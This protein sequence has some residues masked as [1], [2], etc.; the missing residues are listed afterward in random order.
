MR[1]SRSLGSDGRGQGGRIGHWLVVGVLGNYRGVRL[2][3]PGGDVGA[4]DTPSI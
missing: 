4:G 2:Y 1:L 3:D